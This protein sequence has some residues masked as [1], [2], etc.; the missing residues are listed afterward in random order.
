MRK[1]Q[2]LG[3]QY[4]GDYEKAFRNTARQMGIDPDEFLDYLK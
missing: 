4:N 2:E 3:E 1:I